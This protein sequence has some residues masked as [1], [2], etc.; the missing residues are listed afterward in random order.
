MQYMLE[1]YEHVLTVMTIGQLPPWGAVNP[2][3]FVIDLVSID[4][5]S[6]TQAMKDVRN[7]NQKNSY[8]MIVTKLIFYICGIS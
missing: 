6:Q 4:H 3:E 1:I 7:E 8:Y 2:A 5:E